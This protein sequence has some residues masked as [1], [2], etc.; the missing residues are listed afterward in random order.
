MDFEIISSE[1]FINS[2]RIRSRFSED[3]IQTKSPQITKKILGPKQKA[4]GKTIVLNENELPFRQNFDSEGVTAAVYRAMENTT[5]L[6]QMQNLFSFAHSNG[7]M[8]GKE[9]LQKFNEATSQGQMPMPMN[10]VA[11]AQGNPQINLPPAMNGYPPQGN[12][13]MRNPAMNPQFASP[14]NANLG[15]PN[16]MMASPHMRPGGSPG[17]AVLPPHM[18]QGAPMGAQQMVAQQSAQGT[19]SA[20]SSNASPNAQSKKRRVSQAE[21]GAPQVNGIMNKTAQTPKMGVQAAKRQKAN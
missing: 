18:Q 12:F 1:E 9:A 20:P 8:S 19:N 21:P 16:A 10:N 6:A 7:I 14:A 3:S 4:K 5:I 11:A 15:L 2:G 17:Q 13:A